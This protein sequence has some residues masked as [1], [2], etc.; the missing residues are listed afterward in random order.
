MSPRPTIDH[1][2]NEPPVDREPGPWR[3]VFP[4]LAVTWALNLYSNPIDWLSVGLGL[5]TGIVFT[6]WILEITGNK[7]PSSWRPKAPRSTLGG[8][9]NL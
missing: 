3:W 5:F 7:V 8:D 2:P 4:V 1:D 9:R 6:A